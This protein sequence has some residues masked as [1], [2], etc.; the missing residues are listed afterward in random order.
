MAAI[1]SPSF[2][3]HVKPPPAKKA[4]TE[5]ATDPDLPIIGITNAIMT[6][7]RDEV[8]ILEG[9]RHFW[10]DEIKAMWKEQFHKKVEH[11][12]EKDKR[13]KPVKLIAGE[14]F[15]VYTVQDQLQ[16]QGVIYNN[17]E[18]ARNIL[19]HMLSKK[20]V[21]TCCFATPEKALTAV[22][23]QDVS[24]VQDDSLAAL[25]NMLSV[26]TDK[27]TDLH[28]QELVMGGVEGGATRDMQRV[29]ETLYA[30]SREEAGL[31]QQE[32]DSRKQFIT[33]SDPYRGSVN[34]IFV[35]TFSYK[36]GMEAIWRR[37]NDLRRPLGGVPRWRCPHAWY[38]C[39][40]GIDKDSA[41]VE[42]ADNET[43]NGR[44]VSVEE[45][46]NREKFCDPKNQAML[47][48]ILGR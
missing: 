36:A 39:I 44:W 16:F 13:G 43:R 25:H 23:T 17:V 47:K 8:F 35:S 24:Q 37:A 19:R 41:K 11:S 1:S 33:F 48:K 9:D 20:W 26:F 2:K 38:K 40:P 45:A 28:Y 34:A 32:V 3:Q 6:P 31:T 21:P 46:L 30:E 7:K 15:Q 5:H 29:R 22:A 4:K 42:K 27:V 18:Q 10:T 14:P 12:T